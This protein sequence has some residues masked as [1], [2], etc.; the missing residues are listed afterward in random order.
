MTMLSNGANIIFNNWGMDVKEESNEQSVYI[1]G[2]LPSVS[3]II[4]IYQLTCIQ[5]HGYQSNIEV[6]SNMQ[7]SLIPNQDLNGVTCLP[8]LK[9]DRPRKSAQQYL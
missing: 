5:F 2:C 9:T 4:I 3:I 6:G 8:S 7:K 1:S